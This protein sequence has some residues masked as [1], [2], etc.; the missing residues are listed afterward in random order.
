MDGDSLSREILLET[1]INFLLTF[2]LKSAKLGPATKK[3]DFAWTAGTMGMA[4][5]AI[6]A[7][8]FCHALRASAD[9]CERGCRRAAAFCFR[10]AEK[11]SAR[12]LGA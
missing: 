2:V 6:M 3:E 8:A 9:S 1:A 11:R 12:E 7:A 10:S 4:I 5:T